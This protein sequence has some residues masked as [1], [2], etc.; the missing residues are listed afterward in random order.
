MGWALVF[1]RYLDGI[2]FGIDKWI[3]IYLTEISFEG[4]SY[5][6]F[7]SLAAGF[8]VY[9]NDGVFWCVSIWLGTCFDV[10]ADVISLGIDKGIYMGSSDRYF[11]VYNNEN[12]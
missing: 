7:E 8:Q 2:T 9:I 12:L 3:Y 1:D 11:E 10:Y 5:G 4:F 6:K